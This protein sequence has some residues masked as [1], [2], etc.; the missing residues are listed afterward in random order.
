[1]FILLSSFS[2][3]ALNA[4]AAE[5][6]VFT[7]GMG[8]GVQSANPFIGIYSSD[9]LLYSYIYDYLIYPNQDG[10]AT[11]NLAKSWWYMDGSYAAA[12]GSSSANLLNRAPSSWPLGSIWEYNLT[13]NVNW[14]DGVPF[15][16][17]DV[18]YTV[19]LQTGSNYATFWA[20][21]PYTKWIDHAQK[22][23]QYKVRFFFTDRTNGS[24]PAVPVS[25]GS[26]INFPIMPKHVLQAYTPITIAQS[27]TGIPAIGTG[28]FKGTSNLAAEIIAKEHVTLVHNSEY[29]IGLGKAYGRVCEIDKLIMKFY[30]EEQTLILDLKAG[31]LDCT[32]I[33][34]INCQFLSQDTTKP[35][36]L[37]LTSLFSLTSYSKISH[38]NFEIGKAPGGLN[39]ARTDPALHR[40]CALATDKEY[41]VDNIFYGFGAPGN[42]IISPAYEK[43]YY[44]PIEDVE[45]SWFNVTA[46][47]TYNRG[48]YD[49][50]TQGAM[51]YSYHGKVKDVMAFN[52]TRANEILNA[53]GYDWPTYPTGYRK[54]GLVAAERLVAMGKAGSIDSAMNDQNGDPR[55]LAFEDILEQEVFEDMDI[56]KY[57]S[58][59]WKEIGVLLVPTAVNVATWNIVVY[60]FLEHFAETYW[61]GDPD[62]NYLLYVPSSYAMDGWNEWGEPDPYYDYCYQRQAAEL[63]EASRKYWT[64]ECEKY[65][66]LSGAAFMCTAYPKSCFAYYDGLRW[67]NWGDWAQHPGLSIDHYWGETPLFFKI[68]YGSDTT[69]PVTSI[70][71]SGSAGWGNWYSSQL[72]ITLDATDVGIGVNN[73]FFEIS[74]IDG[75]TM[76]PVM[77]GTYAAM[78]ATNL[79]N[80]RYVLNY[81]SMDYLGN[82]EMQGQFYFGIDD[83]PPTLELIQVNGTS[84]Y[85]GTVTLSW[86]ASDEF[87]GI[88]KIEFSLDD[89][90]F[91]LLRKDSASQTMKGL[92]NGNHHAIIR[93][94]DNAGLSVEKEISFTVSA[95]SSDDTIWSL[96]L[97]GEIV[98]VSE[99]LVISYLLI[100]RKGKTPLP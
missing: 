44:N 62:P 100:R 31:V 46:N 67:T 59:Q 47:A 66:Y 96:I 95:S 3:F 45:Q 11:P 99:V 22:V 2:P 79:A 54:V 57:L 30:S 70:T 85:S 29:D 60:N 41:I 78:I 52:V 69:P 87:S 94:T 38:F 14:S 16:A 64:D 19:S 88:A 7:I 37:K 68:H 24:N 86:L 82:Q 56:S 10:N 18:V 15:N 74:R 84:F 76:T 90:E 39:P 13:Q 81:S 43:W 6:R 28:P 58:A 4:S 20:Y 55:Y 50:T 83:D 40:A 80:G 5:E 97:V 1:L 17:D 71:A 8:E 63:N 9:Y 34:P 89:S 27:W 23:D 26:S 65:L 91:S 53:S 25:W 75:T 42:G 61:S 92:A 93:V 73:T 32:E 51:L 98:L 49:A 77:S 36:G 33:T 35:T 48:I 12:H 21:Q 72:K